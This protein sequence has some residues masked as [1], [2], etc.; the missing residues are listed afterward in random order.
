MMKRNLRNFL[1]ATLFAA[2]APLLSAP[3]MAQ[4][5]PMMPF[6]HGAERLAEKLNLTP[7]QRTQWDAMVQ[8]S[9]AQFEAMRAAHHEMHEAMQAELA[10]PEPDLAALAAK[11]DAARARGMA[12]HKEL[13]DGWLKLYATMSPEQKGVVKKAILWHMEKMHHMRMRMMHHHHHG[14]H[15]HHHHHHG[16]DGEHGDWGHG[17]HGDHG[18]RHHG[19]GPPPK[20]N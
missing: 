7:A 18:D 8:K 10:K 4:G 20:T 1:L 15:H 6:G 19:D 3:A 12:A 13:R 11:A 14:H 2:A 9:K 16:D 5:M 17:D